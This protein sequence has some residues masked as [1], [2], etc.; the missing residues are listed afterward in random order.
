MTVN[1]HIFF[2]GLTYQTKSLL[3]DGLPEIS[4]M[5]Y[6]IPGT[7]ISGFADSYKKIII[8]MATDRP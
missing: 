3:H 2:V 6:R 7:T 5:I 4:K 8:I 1:T